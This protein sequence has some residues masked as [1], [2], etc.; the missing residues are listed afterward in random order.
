LRLVVDWD[1]TVTATDSLWIVLGRFGDPEIFAQVE[2]KLVKGAISYRELMEI[3]FATV[4][5]PL[6]DV[7]AHLVEHARLGPGFHELAETYEPLVLSSGFEQLI[8]PLLAREGIELDVLANRIDPRPDGWRV[9]WRDET[10]C[11]HCG[12]RCKRG[13]LPTGDVV[14]VGDGYS[15]RCAALAARRVFARDGLADYLR[16]EGV[17]FEPFEDFYDVAKALDLK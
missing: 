6:E 3:E 15:D 10:T 17:P 11:D 9:L 14:Y 7:V 5:A 16:D 8:R 4:R 12:D 2:G 1:G 13:G